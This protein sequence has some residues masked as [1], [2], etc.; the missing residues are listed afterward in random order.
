MPWPVVIAAN[1]YGI[2][3]TES[4]SDFAIPAEITDNGYGTPVVL[5]DSGG[6]PVKGVGG[7]GDTPPAG[8]A[9]LTDFEGNSL[10][11]ADGVRLYGAI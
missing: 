5:V 4:D 6:T 11:D 10:F 8:F 1:G 2:P 3:V 7:G 9:W